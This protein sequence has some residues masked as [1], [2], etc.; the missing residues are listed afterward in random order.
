MARDT[1]HGLGAGHLRVTGRGLGDRKEEGPLSHLCFYRRF[2]QAE[3]LHCTFNTQGSV[4][5]LRPVGIQFSSR[6]LM[7]ADRRYLVSFSQAS[8]PLRPP[9]PSLSPSLPPSGG[10]GVGGSLVQEKRRTSTPFI[11]NLLL[12]LSRILAIKFSTGSADKQTC[13][14]IDKSCTRTHLLL[15][16][17]RG[18]LS[19]AVV[20][21]HF[22]NHRKQRRRIFFFFLRSKAL[23]TGKGG[24]FTYGVREQ[25]AECHPGVPAA[26]PL[27]FQKLIPV[28]NDSA[29]DRAHSLTRGRSPALPCLLP[30][31]KQLPAASH[32]EKNL[33]KPCMMMR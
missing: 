24:W 18:L 13:N 7:D 2:F 8:T 21:P 28:S 30:E 33:I 25:R 14:S 12:L 19:L 6:T 16:I 23:I 9:S 26:S 17:E 4:L 5:Q 1:C 31:S 29:R 27:I 22:P 10:G 32:L 3:G 20:V 15:L 11:Y